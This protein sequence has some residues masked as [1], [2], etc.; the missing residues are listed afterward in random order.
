MDK[1]IY[2]IGPRC[3]FHKTLFGVIHN[4]N[5]VTLVKI[6]VNMLIAVYITPKKSF[7]KLANRRQFHK[8]FFGIIHAPQH[9]LS[10]NLW[11]YANISVNY[12]EIFL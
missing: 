12:A 1:K 8:T 4:P 11:Q 5:G 10:Q 7:M 3:Q 2:N 9:N 6:Y